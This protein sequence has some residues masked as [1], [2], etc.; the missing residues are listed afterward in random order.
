M[1]ELQ[2]Q[3]AIQSSLR[4]IWE[5][6]NNVEGWWVLSSSDH[7]SLEFFSQEHSLQKGMRA[8]LK[9]Q[10]GGIRG[11]SRGMIAQVIPEKE[12]V[13]ESEKAVYSHLFFHIPVKQTVIWIMEENGKEAVLSMK[14]RLIFSNTA[15]GRVS[16]W[17]FVHVLR[18]KQLVSDHS[19]K[20]LLYIKKAIEGVDKSS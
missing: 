18:G 8:M 20:E 2:A 5:Y 9:E 12:V 4:M 16:E 3:V 15:W 13:W 10:F 17:Y 7:V 11:E 14:V 19:L 6:M 1:L